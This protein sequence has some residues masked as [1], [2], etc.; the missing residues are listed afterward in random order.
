MYS[1]GQYFL[2]Y[3][4]VQILLKN[5]QNNKTLLLSYVFRNQNNVIVFGDDGLFGDIYHDMYPEELVLLDTNINRNVYYLDL[6]IFFIQWC[7]QILLL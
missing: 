5:H 1:S 4:R 3:V 2:I 7:F 6:N